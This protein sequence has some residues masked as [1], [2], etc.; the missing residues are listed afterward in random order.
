MADY[1][2]KNDMTKGIVDVYEKFAQDFDTAVNKMITDAQ[3]GASS[4]SSAASTTNVTNTAQGD[5]SSN[6]PST[7]NTA[8]LTTDALVV[9]AKQSLRDTVSG[10]ANTIFTTLRKLAQKL[11]S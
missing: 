5:S 8:Q 2:V 6:Q 9:Q 4:A 3:G 10:V 1:N 7:V 11:D